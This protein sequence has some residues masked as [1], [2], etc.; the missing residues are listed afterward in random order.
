M[1]KAFKFFIAAFLLLI[2]TLSPS[3]S[4]G[5]D[6]LPAELKAISKRG[7]D[8]V[9][10]VELDKAQAEFEEAVSKYPEHPF[11]HFGLAMVKWAHFEYLE[12]E[13]NPAM[14][15]EYD[16]FTDKAVEVG[17][18]WLKK[19]P[20]DGNAHLCMG[21]MYGLRA[22]LYLMRHSW[23]KAYIN[24]K[25]ALSSMHKALKIDPELYDAYLGLG[26]YEYSAGTLPKVIR[27]LS[28][29]IMS[30]DAGKGIEYLELCKDKGY[31]NAV[32]AKLLLIE[33]FTQT[34]S[35][36]SNPKQAVEWSNELRKIYPRHAQ[37]HFVQIVSLYEARMYDE[38]EREMKEYLSRV[39]KGFPQYKR[40]FLPRILVSLGT[41]NMV[42]G[43]YGSALDYF[44]RARET[45]K[46]EK[47]PSRWAVWGVVR[48]GNLYDAEKMR[49]RAVETYKEALSYRDEWGFRDYIEKY[50][51]TPF[52]SK[53][54]PDQ[55]PPP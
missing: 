12:E 53:L 31:F 30:G 44:Q 33:I 15:R 52:D 40:K 2:G 14:D 4:G 27:W 42:K 10:A 24:G 28:R 54:I 3:F 7:M 51:D 45:I 32:A 41:I 39:E 1:K 20:D 11:G 5:K 8:Y 37:M 29:L 38:S 13:S 6:E 17:K 46:E 16:Q 19:H 26:L 48:I 34:N 35:P 9:C 22:R 47:H 55:L 25:R 23:L 21:G 50:L 36:Y 43:D 18:K 49:E